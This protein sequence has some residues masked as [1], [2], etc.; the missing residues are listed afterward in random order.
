MARIEPALPNLDHALAGA[1]AAGRSS[2]ACGALSPAQALLP[3]RVFLGATFVYAGAQKLS[4]P[5]F[6][7]PGAP[8]YIGTQLRGFAHG[9]PGGVLLRTFALPHAQ[10]GGHRGRDHG[11]RRRAARPRSGSPRAR[12][13]W[14]GSGSTWCCSSPRA[15]R[16]HR[17]SSAPTSSSCSPGCRSCSPAATGSPRWSA[18]AVAARSVPAEAAPRAGRRWPRP[19]RAS[20]SPAP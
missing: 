19:A 3:L 8:T 7:H 5:G 11:D 15:G 2:P 18:C 10:A 14:P 1:G 9:T 20:R 6:L 4:D 12:R 16:R 17:T 13:R